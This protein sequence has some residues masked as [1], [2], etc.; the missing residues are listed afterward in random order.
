[1]DSFFMYFIIFRERGTSLKKL[2]HIAEGPTTLRGVRTTLL[3]EGLGDS[4]EWSY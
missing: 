2:L 1:M 4:V 3:V